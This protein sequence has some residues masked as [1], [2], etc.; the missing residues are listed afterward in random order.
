MGV[1]PAHPSQ[2]PTDVRFFC[3][4]LGGLSLHLN[5]L[6]PQRM[7][8]CDGHL[9]HFRLEFFC[10]IWTQDTLRHILGP[11]MAIF[12]ICQFLTAPGPFENF[13][14][15][16]PFRKSKI[17]RKRLADTCFLGFNMRWADD[18]ATR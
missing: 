1:P 13:Q 15:M 12:E 4:F 2:L 14:K 8:I 16:G 10:Q 6:L 9:G 18:W 11:I 17:S 3:L 7:A 5:H